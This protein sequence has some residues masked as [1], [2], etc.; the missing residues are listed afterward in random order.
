MAEAGKQQEGGF[1]GLFKKKTAAPKI[2]TEKVKE[3]V[4]ESTALMAPLL[5]TVL[6]EKFPVRIFLGNSSFSYFTHFEWE[7]VEDENGRVAESK[8]HL[9]EGLYLLVAP[10]DPPIGNL[11]IRSATEIRAEFASEYHLLECVTTLIRFTPERKICLSFPTSLRQKPQKRAAVRVPVDRNMKIV[12]SVVR[13]SGIVFAA[14]VLDISA[15]GAAFAPT[16]ATPRIADHSRVEL[17]FS[18]PTGKAVVDA[19]IL[20]S[21]LKDGETVFRAQFLVASHQISC[22]VNLLVSYVQRENLQRRAQFTE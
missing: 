14:R 20:G 12:A 22:D 5:I 4:L 8:I 11:K 17:S 1:L 6:K 2:P 15:S 9:E 13:P 16:G 19:V 21:V 18:Y 7:L 10:L 3:A